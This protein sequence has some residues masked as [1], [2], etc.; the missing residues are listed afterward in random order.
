M[1][2]SEFAVVSILTL[3][4]AATLVACG[5]DAT[6]SEGQSEAA[7]ESSDVI[8]DS[9]EADEPGEVV[10][11]GVWSRRP[12]P[13]QTTVAVYAEVTNGTDEDRRLVSASS[14]ATERVE[15]HETVF[16]D[17]GVAT[18][19]A[20]DDG[21]VVPAGGVLRFEPG[22]AHVM[23]RDMDADAIGSTIDVVFVFDDGESIE[24][25]AEVRADAPAG[26][27]TD[28]DHADS[29]ATAD[30]DAD[31]DHDHADSDATADAD[32]DADH[33]HADSDATAETLDLDV[34]ALHHVDDE[35]S[36]G[37]LDV[38]AQRAVVADYIA[39]LEALEPAEDSGATELLDLL[40]EL[41]GALEQQDLAASAVLAK[42]AH[43]IAHA[44]VPHS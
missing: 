16:D 37:T 30:A 19:E 20:R 6:E 41:D 13:G 22:G 43:I 7:V 1:K 3:A 18:M 34:T 33:D 26:D 24:A 35:L 10:I 27:H 9:A 44:L 28:H 2:L 5:S 40:R 21:F 23:L 11:A 15:L 36:A 4:M 31:A 17:N 42:R 8:D 25:T 12:A 32:A 39:E 38:D 14:S 29:D